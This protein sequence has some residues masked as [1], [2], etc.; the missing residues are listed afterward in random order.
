MKVSNTMKALGLLSTKL[1]KPITVNVIATFDHKEQEFF[2]LDLPTKEIVDN[3]DLIIKFIIFAMRVD[4]KD[5]L[6]KLSLSF[7][8]DLDFLDQFQGI[9]NS[10][11]N[12]GKYYFNVEINEPNNIEENI[13]EYL[14]QINSF[15]SFNLP[16]KKVHETAFEQE[17]MKAIK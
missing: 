7:K 8:G 12:N 10:I 11:N 9:K 15:L 1:E 3:E 16:L 6:V 14:R 5:R 4:P 17:I 13:L 2:D